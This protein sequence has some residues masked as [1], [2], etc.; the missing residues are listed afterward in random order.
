MRARSR[1]VPFLS[2][3]RAQIPSSPSPFNACHAG[4]KNLGSASGWLKQ[5][6][7]QPEVLSRSW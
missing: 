6:L 3:S 1:E 2:P 7:N 5:F 4:Y